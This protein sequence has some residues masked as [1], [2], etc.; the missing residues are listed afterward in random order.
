MTQASH[1]QLG[2]IGH[3]VEHSQ[4]PALFKTILARDQR[5]DVTYEAFDL[6][7]VASFP[8]FV[9]KHPHLRGL[10]VTAP[11]KQGMLSMLTDLSPEA[12]ALGAVNTLVLTPSGWEGHNTDVWG[13]QRSIQPFLM[14]R[15][16]RALVLGTGGSAAAVHHVLRNLGIETLS[17]SRSAD[18]TKATE[19]FGSPTIGYH[20][21]NAPLLHHHL[22]VVHCTPVGMW[23]NTQA[24]VAFPVG[25]LTPNHLVMD[26][27]YN[28]SET[29]LLRRAKA[30]G[31]AT[32]NG[33]DMLRLQAEK[34]WE[35]WQEAGV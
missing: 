9:E 22:L 13:F 7:K 27:V 32:L 33:A 25:L 18:S 10:N 24:S 20:E 4:S 16:E 19:A 3:P 12:E 5:E 14:N 28:P 11:H 1:A 17:V 34:A 35:I 23:P 21:L 31:A 6:P 2:L 15:H 29:L 30:Q 8:S 26:L